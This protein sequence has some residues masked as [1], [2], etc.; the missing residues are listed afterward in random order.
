RGLARRAS[1]Q[2]EWC[3]SKDGPRA[4]DTAPEAEPSLDTLVLLCERCRDIADGQSADP[5]TLRF[6]EGAIWSEVPAIKEPAVEALGRLEVEWAK[7]ALDMIATY[8]DPDADE[9]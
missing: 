3:E 7:E 8:D 5:R 6:L 9:E 1:S 2:C 4:Y